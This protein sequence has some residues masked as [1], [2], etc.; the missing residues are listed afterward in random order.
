MK[1]K[2]KN[3]RKKSKTTYYYDTRLNKNFHTIIICVLMV[4]ENPCC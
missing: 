3:V 2:N 1:V 4:V